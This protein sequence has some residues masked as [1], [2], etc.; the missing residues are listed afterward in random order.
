MIEAMKSDELA[1]IDLTEGEIDA[2]MAQSQ[3]VEVAGPPDTPRDVRFELFMSG[4]HTYR[5]RLVAADGEILA[6]SANAY[7]SRT[8]A[9]KS[10]AVLTGALAGAPIVDVDELVAS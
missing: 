10:L 5:W 4:A 8:E 1:E 3:P 9:Y 2:M 7:R 6:T